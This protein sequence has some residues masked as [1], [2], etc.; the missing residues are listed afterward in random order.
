[1]SLSVHDLRDFATGHG[2]PAPR[3]GLAKLGDLGFLRAAGTLALRFVFTMIATFSLALLIWG[4]IIAPPKKPANAWNGRDNWE[5]GWDASGANTYPA[6]AYKR[7]SAWIESMSGG[8]EEAARRNRDRDASMQR[9]ELSGGV[10]IFNRLA[11]LGSGGSARSGGGGGLDLSKLFGEPGKPASSAP[12]STTSTPSQGESFLS[13]LSLPS[14]PE[15]ST[16]P[17]NAFREVAAERNLA[18]PAAPARHIE[19]PAPAPQGGFRQAAPPQ[20]QASPNARLPAPTQPVAPPPAAAPPSSGASDAAAATAALRAAQADFRH[21]E[22][23]RAAVEAFAGKHPDLP[24][25]RDLSAE[26]ATL[27]ESRRAAIVERTTLDTSGDRFQA[28]S[29]SEQA[30]I[31]ACV[32]N[33]G[34]VTGMIIARKT[35]AIQPSIPAYIVLAVAPGLPAGDRE[36]ERMV[37]DRLHA[38]LAPL[39]RSG[40]AEVFVGPTEPGGPGAF[41]KLSRTAGVVVWKP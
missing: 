2:Q 3:N 4:M 13:K 15:S 10:D 9:R 1:M 35:V 32:R 8:Y 6:L 34:V 28:A 33:T 37:T 19:T 25:S 12:S 24:A 30:A 7:L 20:P 18:T 21:F 27:T 17:K 26:L 40:T 41:D 31:G 39:H 29:V 16:P 11:S 38:C 22:T 36:K 5:S 23:A 14:L